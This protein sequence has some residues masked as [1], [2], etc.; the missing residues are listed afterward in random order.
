MELILLVIA[1]FPLGYFIRSR[2]VAYITYIAVQA[3]VF[4]YQ[5]A[6]LVLEWVGGSKTAFG[7]YPHASGQHIVGYGIVNLAIYAAGLGLVTLGAHL[8]GRRRT[9]DTALNLDA[10]HA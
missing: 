1:P 2:T 9:K 4:T 8:A 7:P 3:F 6:D 5:T 10:H